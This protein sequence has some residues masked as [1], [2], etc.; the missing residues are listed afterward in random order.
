[1]EEHVH[2]Q[3][4]SVADEVPK[5][6]EGVFGV[7]KIIFTYLTLQLGLSKSN[8]VLI[9]NPFKSGRNKIMRNVPAA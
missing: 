1:V 3:F 4:K 6:F 2:T 8:F 7:P 9:H 5:Y